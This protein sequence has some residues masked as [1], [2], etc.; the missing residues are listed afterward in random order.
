MKKLIPLLFILSFTA[1]TKE[2]FD[3]NRTK[4]FSIH[5]VSTGAT[6]QIKVGLPEN[7][8]SDKKY[9]TVY[10]LDGEENFDFVAK[11]CKKISDDNSMQNVLV[12]SIGYGNDRIR[13]YTPTV[14]DEGEGG[15]SKFMEFIKGE[16][17]PKIDSDFYADTLRSSRVIL[18]HSFGGLLGA[19]AFTNYNYVF[20]NYI[21][22][23]PSIWYDNEVMLRF[24][25]ENRTLNNKNQQLVFMGIGELENAGRMQAPFEAFYQRLLNNYTG[26]KISKHIVPHL[27]HMGSKNESIEVG[28]KFY[29]QNK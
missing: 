7:Y 20:G 29:F 2:E 11:K 8:S 15:A 12:I 22:L 4:E 27:D 21:L 26:I 19:Y 13:D 6:Y 24:E 17:I 9:A 1:C 10:V 3:V 18:G 28:L 16:L 23:S 25:Q 14:A 5:S